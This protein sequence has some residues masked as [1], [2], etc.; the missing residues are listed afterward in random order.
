MIEEVDVYNW[1]RQQE[2]N[3]VW[4]GRTGYGMAR[5][6]HNILWDWT[7]FCGI[8]FGFNN[9]FGQAALFFCL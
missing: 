9:L 3:E 1:N 8:Y 7:R 6:G 4:K 5:G 2:S